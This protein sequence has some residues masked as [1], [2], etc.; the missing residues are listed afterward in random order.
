MRPLAGDA[1]GRRYFRIGNGGQSMIAMDSPPH[2]KLPQFLAVRDFLAAAG[3]HVP[4]LLAADAARGF[5]LLSDFGD[6]TYF[7]AINENNYDELYAAA[8]TT[9]IK[10]QSRPPAGLLPNYDAQLLGDEMQLYADW[11]CRQHLQQPLSQREKEV[12]FRATNFLIRECLAQ[13][14]VVVHRD[15]HS[16]NLMVAAPLPGVLDFQD[17]VVG[18]ATYD[19]VSL[20]R[21]AYVCWPATRQQEW[22]AQYRQQAAAAGGALPGAK[23]FARDFNV[24]GVQRGLKV[25]GIFARLSRRDHKPAYLTDMPLVYRHLA[26]AGD[27]VPELAELMHIVRRRPPCAP[28]S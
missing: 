10:I 1:S 4:G 19:M 27:A 20:L 8:I 3:V 17:A 26:T 9:L 25:L 2:E 28:S 15:Y 7:S 5:A 14:Q 12:F 18:P 11:Y 16:R 24:T 23:K 13:P 21:D 6:A 22:L